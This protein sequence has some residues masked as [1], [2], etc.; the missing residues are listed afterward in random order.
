MIVFLEGIMLIMVKIYPE[1]SGNLWD[2]L[3]RIKK[4][5]YMILDEPS[6]ALAPIAEDK[7]FKQFYCLGEGKS[8]VIISHRLSNEVLADKILVLEN[9]RIIEQGSHNELLNNNGEYAHLFNLQASKY[10]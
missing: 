2:L 3:E 7:I 8:P 1:G 4:S 9:G 10:L 6:A 5:E